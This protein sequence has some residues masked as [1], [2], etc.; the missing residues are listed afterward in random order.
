MII[1]DKHSGQLCNRLWSLL[2]VISF[3]L[4]KNI[5]ILVLWSPKDVVSYFTSLAGAKNIHFYFSGIKKFSWWWRINVLLEKTNNYINEPLE[6]FQAKNTK[7]YFIDA[8]KHSE[9]V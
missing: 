8:W 9:D 4:E 2:P 5:K 1:I 3:S 7:I 6:T